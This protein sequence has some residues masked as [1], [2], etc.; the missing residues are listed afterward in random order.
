MGKY[1]NIDTEVYKL[2]GT[3]TWK[4]E[5][6][7]TFPS[8]FVSRDKVSEFIRVSVV[9]S[10][11]GLNRKS[12]SGI[13]MIDIFTKAGDGPKRSS[14]IADKLDSYLS[15]K[16]LSATAGVAI[17]FPESSAMDS[18]GTDKDNPTLY[19]V[20]YTIPFKYFEVL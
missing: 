8:N 18:K 16:S 7:K 4:A 6:I 1:L 3:D 5:K 15:G 14:I 10:G 2:F 17:Q 11:N 12:V 19:R 13:L 20:A 9:P